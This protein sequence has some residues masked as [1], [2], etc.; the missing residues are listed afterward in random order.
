MIGQTR[1]VLVEG[2]NPAIRPNSGFGSASTDAASAQTS[3]QIRWSGRSSSNH[4]I[5]FTVPDDPVEDKQLLTG[6]IADIMIE[7]A[8]AHS[9]WGYLVHGPTSATPKKGETTI[10]A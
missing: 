1:Q 5:H 10:A 6:T 4:I 3:N 2:P 8:H 9:L 7:G